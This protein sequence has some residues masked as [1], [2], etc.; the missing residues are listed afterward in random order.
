MITIEIKIS[1]RTATRLDRARHHLD[2]CPPS[3]DYSEI[4]IA[5]LDAADLKVDVVDGASREN[6]R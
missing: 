4:V 6:E 2:D 1:D 5:A 3:A